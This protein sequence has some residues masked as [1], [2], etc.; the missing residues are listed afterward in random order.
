MLLLS[1]APCYY[2]LRCSLN[3]CVLATS[4]L[5]LI[6]ALQD[7]SDWVSVMVDA[8]IYFGTYRKNNYQLCF[9]AG[10]LFQGPDD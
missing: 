8:C 10:S 5:L 9:P 3:F 2:I 4:E 6:L 1:S 7:L